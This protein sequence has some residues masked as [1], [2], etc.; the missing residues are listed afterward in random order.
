MQVRRTFELL[1]VSCV[2]ATLLSAQGLTTTA[3]KDDWEEI[4]F[5]FNSSIL[6][7]GYPSLLRLA[8]LLQQHRD[9]K[10][11]LDANADWIGSHRYNDKL[12]QARGEA[13]QKFLVKYGASE[14]QI[15]VVP[16][17]K[18]TPEVSNETREGRFIN[19]RVSVLVMDGQGKTV[20]A[21]GISEAIKAIQQANQA[22]QQKHRDCCDAIL[23]RL[24]KLDEILAAIKDLK[25]ENDKLKQDVAALQQAQAGVQKQVAELPK[26]P[27]QAEMQ[28]M[29]D[30]TATKAIEQAKP[31]RFSLLGL[32]I[33]PSLGSANGPNGPN[34]SH[35]GNSTIDGTA[36]YFAPFGKD[37][38][39]AIQAQGEYMYYQ[40]RQEGQ[41]DLGL[42]NRWNNLQ[43]GL[44]DSTKYVYIK[45]LAS[46]GT[47]AEGA[48]AVDY[49]FKDGRIGLFATKGYLNEAVLARSP[50]QTAPGLTSFNVWNETYLRVTDQ[51]GASTSL[52]L[53]KDAYVEGNFGAVFRQGGGNKPGGT[54]RLIQPINSVWAFTVEAG[55]N[56]SLIGNTNSGRIAV[57]VQLGNW[58]KPKQFTQVTQAVPMEVPRLRYEMLTRQVRTGNTPPVANAGPNQ[59]GVPAGTITLDGSAS[60]DPDG[61]PITFSWSQTAGSPV[62]LSAPTA[63][64]TTFTAAAGQTYS[65][66]LTVKDPYGAQ[67]TASVT[68]TTKAIP[69][70]SI[71]EFAAHPP[72]IIAGQSS[73]LSWRIANATSAQISGIGSVNAQNGTTTVSPTQTTT[74]TL[75]ATGPS[76]SVTATA[77]VTVGP[78]AQPAILSFQAIPASIVAGRSSTLVW[79][80]QN[81]DTVSIAGLGALAL[82]GSTSVSPTETTTYTM[83]AT[84]KAGSTTATVTVTVNPTRPPNIVSF[85]A[86]PSQITAGGVSTLT[87]Q[88]EHATSVTISSLGTVGSA[89]SQGVTPS[90]TTTYTLTATN[91]GG[92]STGTATVTVLVPASILSFTATPSTITA[93]QTVTLSWTTSNATTAKLYN[94]GPVSPNG[95]LQVNPT[96]TTIYTL[97]VSGA[98]GLPSTAQ[99]TVN[100]NPV[101]AAKPPVAAAVPGG[102]VT[103]NQITVSAQ[104]TYD[105]NGLPLTYSWTCSNPAATIANPA[106]QTSAVFL[107]HNPGTFVFTVTV[108]NS[109]GLSSTASTTFTLIQTAP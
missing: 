43:V 60:Y 21:G 40:D 54:I 27:E 63:A 56:E 95:S 24:D 45:D 16:H 5:E 51:I 23:K 11:R 59:I 76:G 73:T 97:Y 38:T 108:T 66:L 77:T 44:F 87:W 81:A 49:L 92:Q 80:T 30:Q 2:C 47:L 100:V 33:G 102:P 20:S 18:R 78:A 53:W 52:G 36:R 74:Y 8:E 106:A 37:D 46:G 109:A 4:N 14:N 57:G 22:E 94:I 32:N 19:R 107:G 62:T 41:F 10:V 103:T 72:N 93:G 86:T 9:Y 25:A 1:A 85:V 90:A 65:F 31:S 29:M 88:V 3:T 58:L 50:V 68:V 91:A 99:V 35:A 64:K 26:A 12:S 15:Q 104:G 71:V 13:V 89:G 55:L 7:D 34:T 75:T 83:T 67:G 82:N 6:S 48:L 17:G 61:D 79:T 101:A 69:V 105:P 42:V 70:L 98:T 28:K 96:A 84:N 39:H